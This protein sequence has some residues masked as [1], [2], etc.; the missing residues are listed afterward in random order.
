MAQLYTLSFI[1]SAVML[2]L[3]IVNYKTRISVYYLLM[4]M[5][6]TISN[7]GYMQMAS[8]RNL[9]SAVYANQIIYL[10]AC[11][12]PFFMLMS[13]ADLCKIHVKAVYQAL[14][15]IYST[16]VFSMV[17]SIGVVDW[18]YAGVSFEIV[19]GTGVFSKVYGPLHIMYPMYVIGAGIVATAFI[20]TAFTKRK[21]VSYVTST[22]LLICMG[23]IDI[24]Y[25][26]QKI[27]HFNYDFIPFSYLISLGG[28]LFLLRRI[29]M[30][31]VT[32]ISTNSMVES[33]AYGFVICDSNGR[34][35]GSDEAAKIWFP[36][37]K[38]LAID[39]VIPKADTLFL[40]QIKKWVS[41]DD[42]RETVLIECD[43][44][45]YEAKHSIIKECKHHNVHCIYL[46]D[47]TKQ[48]QYTKLVQQY[49]ENLERDVENKTKNLRKIQNDILKS[50]ANIV[51]NRDNNTGGHI[52]R[53]SDIVMIFVDYLQ[54]NSSF[55]ELTPHMANS[56]VKAAPLHD[57]GKIAIPD[58]VLNKP[59]K[60]T[61]EEYEIMKQHSAK[62]AVIVEQILHHVDDAKFRQIAVNVAH[63]HHEK[64][65]GRGYPEGISGTD[66]PFEARV[67]AL[68]D[69]F[70]ALV[71]KRVYKESF[72]YDRAFNIIEESCGSHFDPDLCKA[73]LECRPQLEALYDSYTD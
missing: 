30:Y 36:E 37:L 60:F 9:E 47:D 5:T 51:E 4:F 52:A 50:M 13:I 56:I 11:F 39:R 25:I 55:A 53:T 66:I 21:E 23:S 46:R 32:V 6:I 57:F 48:Q 15:L 10:G 2:T 67:M 34:Y 16:F 43:E 24:V 3:L 19:N 44:N 61:D 12:T 59:G 65:D 28:I 17:S 41:D 71:S 70:D 72:G 38:E 68:A 58:I 54:A 42:D 73:F 14:I 7:F 20:I 45:I 31:E 18:F 35:L 40:A 69:V 63:F 64:W 27:F 33:L 62:G 49:S 22:L 8:A 29:S 26:V 1:A